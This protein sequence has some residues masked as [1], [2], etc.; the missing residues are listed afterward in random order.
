MLSY[1]ALASW[2]EVWK[3]A[4]GQIKTQ[5][6]RENFYVLFHVYETRALIFSVAGNQATQT[7]NEQRSSVQKLEGADRKCVHQSAERRTNDRETE[8]KKKTSQ[9]KCCPHK[10]HFRD[11][12]GDQLLKRRRVEIIR[13]NDHER[14]DVLSLQG[15]TKRDKR[16][17]SN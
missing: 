11:D 16:N 8:R 14:R 3:V 2:E 17:Q 6:E 7:Q 15:Q 13:R 12:D 9:I 10:S 4:V 5:Q 1:Q